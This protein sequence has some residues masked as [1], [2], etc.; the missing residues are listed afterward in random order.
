MKSRSKFSILIA[1]IC[2]MLMTAS[3]I[4]GAFSDA[5]SIDYEAQ[6]KAPTATNAIADY[7]AEIEWGANGTLKNLT[8]NAIGITANGNRYRIVRSPAGAITPNS[9]T[10]TYASQISLYEAD[11]SA[12]AQYAF[13]YNSTVN[14][15]YATLD[16][17]FTVAGYTVKTTESGST[18]Y[19]VY[20]PDE[21]PEGISPEDSNV[22]L[23]IVSGTNLV[24]TVSFI[25][26]SGDST[27]KDT[28]ATSIYILK[29][30]ESGE[31]FYADASTLAKATKTIKMSEDPNVFDHIT[32][33]Y[34]TRTNTSNQ[35]TIMMSYYINGELI[36]NK[37]CVPF[38]QNAITISLASIGFNW[39]KSSSKPSAHAFGID[40]LALNFYSANYKS[41][42]YG[43]DDVY[44]TGMD[45]SKQSDL[46][47][48][49]DYISANG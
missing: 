6:L 27:V 47:Y 8:E 7:D 1:M 26:A 42:G 13:K 43:A 41:S 21:L 34:F 40:N 23:A 12:S 44:S 19:R 36:Y 3:I 29:D 38:D 16:F 9:D 45:F 18:V 32:V 4:A 25:K 10:G 17:D 28:R 2:V 35:T 22:D 37:S 31:W 30:S 11:D 49:K 20:T 33:V 46:V 14:S 39:S 24:N 5:A 15:K 48:T